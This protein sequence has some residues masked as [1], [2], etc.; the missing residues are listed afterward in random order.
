[1]PGPTPQYPPEVKREAVRLVRS[2]PDRTIPQIANEIGVSDNSLR[3]W[4]KQAEVDEGKA[5]GLTTDEREE[6]RRLRREVRTLKQ[7]SDFLKKAAPSSPGRKGLKVSCFELIEAERASFPVLLMC[8]MLW[9]SL[10]A[11]TT[12]GG[13]GR[14]PPGRRPMPTS[15]S[16]SRRS[17]KE[18]ERPT[19]P[20]GSTLS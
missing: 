7:E 9:A 16:G 1:V 18:A 11:A 14:P 19:V 13:V 10:G 15:R 4:L 6:L 17:T 12:A 8:R 3:S 2:S 5:D 20:Q